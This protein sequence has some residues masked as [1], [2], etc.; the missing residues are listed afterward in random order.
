MCVRAHVCDGTGREC[1]C[2]HLSRGKEQAHSFCVAVYNVT[3]C[4]SLFCHVPVYFVMPVCFVTPCSN[5]FCPCSTLFCHS[6]FQFCHYMFQSILSFH[7]LVYSVTPCCSLFCH[8]VFQSIL[9]LHVAV[10]S[11][12]PCCSLFCHSVLQS[13]LSLCVAVYSVTPCCSLFCHSMLQSILTIGDELLKDGNAWANMSVSQQH[14]TAATLL[15][16]MEMTGLLAASTMDVGASNTTRRAN[17]GQCTSQLPQL[18]CLTQTCGR[19]M[20]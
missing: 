8:F 14:S 6:M 15:D 9:S 18:P 17:I 19:G 13:V 5:L 12:T 1:V 20:V 7:V 11:V 2:L 16:S 3:P 10:Y 4:S